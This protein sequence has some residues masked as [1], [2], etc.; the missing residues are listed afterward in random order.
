MRSMNRSD[1][2][3]RRKCGPN[4]RANGEESVQAT[5]KAVFL[6]LAV[7]ITSLVS[8]SRARAQEAAAVDPAL[9]DQ[10]AKVWKSKSCDGCHSI[11]KGKRAGPDLAGVTSRRSADWLTQWLKDPPAMAK[12][13]ETAKAMV[14]EA[15]GT[16]MPNFRLKDDEI[17]ALINYMGREGAAK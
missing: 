17:K 5:S 16:V 10:G 9:A 4:T 14:K 8:T 11:G 3:T 15:Q 7:V 12:T 6:T 13:D 1:Y 2:F